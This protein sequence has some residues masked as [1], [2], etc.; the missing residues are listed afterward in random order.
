MCF[1]N[2]KKFKTTTATKLP[3][4]TVKVPRG[5]LVLSLQPLLKKVSSVQKM[6][7]PETHTPTCA[8][9]GA[10][11]FL[12]ENFFNPPGENLAVILY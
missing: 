11:D 9:L 3:V 10:H 4:K 1:Q 7:T 12:L 6:K 5:G 2:T 8:R